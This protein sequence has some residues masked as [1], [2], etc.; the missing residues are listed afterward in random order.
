MHEFSACIIIELME[1]RRSSLRLLLGLFAIGV[2]SRLPLRSGVLYT[3]DS[4]QYALGMEHF[5]VAGHQPP[6]PGAFLYVML[7][8]LLGR[9]VHNPNAV[10]GLMSIAAGG[11][12]VAVLYELALILTG[13]R[14]A[15]WAAF[16]L[17]LTSPILWQYSTVASIYVP[18]A[19]MAS[20]FCLICLR[21]MRG[22]HGLAW[23]ASIALA[24]LAGIRPSTAIMLAPLWLFCMRDLHIRRIAHCIALASAA[25]LAWA[26]PMVMMSGGLVR[27]MGAYDELYAFALAP[28]SPLRSGLPLALAY[29]KLALRYIFMGVGVGFA[30]ALVHLILRPQESWRA[31]KSREFAFVLLMFAPHALSLVFIYNSP[32]DPGLSI[33]LLPGLVIAMAAA[34]AGLLERRR[35]ARRVAAVVLAAALAYNAHTFL[36]EPGQAS[37]HFIRAQQGLVIN[38]LRTVRSEFA[39]GEAVMLGRHH[40]YFGPRHFMYYLPQYH[41]YIYDEGVD[42]H[43]NPRQIMSCYGRRT[44]MSDE[45]ILPASAQS[46]V[47]Q[48][49][50]KGL[51]YR[52]RPEEIA[53]VS[54]IHDL[55]GQ[56]VGYTGPVALLS[57]MLRPL[58]VRQSE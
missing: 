43:G 55:S 2:A 24:A 49:A 41:V 45:L 14:A 37:L 53:Q 50:D 34:W 11:A 27:Y 21:I 4:V 54:E 28:A 48:S 26:I 10:L 39:P 25:T 3:W 12:L 56:G 20:L 18:D 15:A 36:I 16:G 30:I 13:R 19:A 5:D 58:E 17:A 29:A 23:A 44:R 22:E 6:P 38:Y 35:Y 47:I 40:L 7:A 9:I 57:Q 52:L 1:Q 51:L 42:E 32:A 8:R 46:F 31:M 33:A